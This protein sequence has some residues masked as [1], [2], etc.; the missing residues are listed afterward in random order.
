MA[1]TPAIEQVLENIN[2]P[3]EMP[4]GP[5]DFQRYDESTDDIFYSQPRF[6]THIDDGAIGALTEYYSQALPP[7]GSKDAAVLDICSSWI[8]HYPAG[9]TAGRISALGMNEEELA[10]NSVATDFAVHDL[11]VDPRLPYE[12]N[13]FNVVTNAVSVDY[14]SKPIEVFQEMHRVLKP[15]GKAIMSFSNRCFPTKAVAIWTSTGDPDHVFIV[16]SYF[17]YSVPGG[18][19]PPKAKDITPPKGL[20]GGSD[21]MYVVYAEKKA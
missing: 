12:D 13:S 17:H 10:R 3:A 15:G 7:S 18:W 1:A 19:T 4:F 6:V 8:S 5:D 21:P 9:Y 16:G 11:N 20:F 14:L 2:W